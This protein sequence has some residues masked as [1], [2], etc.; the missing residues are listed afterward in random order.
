MLVV[1]IARLMSRLL[2]V[3]G[4]Y[5]PSRQRVQKVRLA[6]SSHDH[7][8]KGRPVSKCFV[9]SAIGVHRINSRSTDSVGDH[10]INAGPVLCY[11]QMTRSI[12]NSESN[13]SVQCGAV[14]SAWIEDSIGSF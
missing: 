3:K 8:I 14:C 12:E 6:T 2:L 5:G 4:G 10:A 1:V 11:G 13:V 9:N 7:A